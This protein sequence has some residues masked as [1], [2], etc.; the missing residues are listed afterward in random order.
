M[1]PY[2]PSNNMTT[3]TNAT[4][5]KCFSIIQSVTNVTTNRALWFQV[6]ILSFG[7]FGL[8]AN[9]LV[10]RS[11]IVLRQSQNQSIRLLMYLS[12][13]DM[14]SAVNNILRFSF[15][16]LAHLVTCPVAQFIHIISLF[17]IFGSIFM[18][19]VTAID[20]Y[21]KVHYLA[22]YEQKFTPLRF[23]IALAWYFLLTLLQTIV[24][25]YFN[26]TYYVGYGSSYTN[27]INIAVILITGALYAKSTHQLRKYKRVNEN[28][29]ENIQNIINIT[30]IYVYLFTIYPVYILII[31][32]L[33]RMKILTKPQ[34][35]VG[36]QIAIQLPCIAGS[37]NA[38]YF[39]LINKEAKDDLILYLRYLKR[40]YLCSQRQVCDVNEP[41]P[42]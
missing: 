29:V 18:F 9:Y 3:T 11:I 39:F 8:V 16:K 33:L 42:A 19:A 17:S 23:R 36:K 26:I 2:F 34:E 5:N 35:V 10:I 1:F 40:T 31:S 13:M 25:G 32:T 30:Q 27:P 20:R 12:M 38:I 22:E 4:F 28:L 21:F 24:A 6:L 15:T 41:Q 7:I 37:I 14:L